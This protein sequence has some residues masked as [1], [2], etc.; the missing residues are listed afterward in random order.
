M[1]D[2]ENLDELI[3]NTKYV[4]STLFNK[5]YLNFN[6]KNK[7]DQIV[8]LKKVSY[9]YISK[10]N[11]IN[12][13]QNIFLSKI[14]LSF[15]NI[16]NRYQPSNED[17][18][19][20]NEC[21]EYL[22]TI[23]KHAGNSE[24]IKIKEF[25]VEE[26]VLYFIKDILKYSLNPVINTTPEMK[27]NKNGLHLENFK[28]TESIKKG[29]L[30]FLENNKDV[31]DYFKEINLKELI[32]SNE[33]EIL[34]KIYEF[35]KFKSIIKRKKYRLKDGGDEE[36]LYDD[37]GRNQI[38]KDNSMNKSDHSK[39]LDK[40]EL[41]NIKKSILKGWRIKI[42]LDNILNSNLF[43]Y[44]YKDIN[45]NGKPQ[46]KR[47]FL[48]DKYDMPDDNDK[49]IKIFKKYLE[50]KTKAHNYIIRYKNYI[51]YKADIYLD[52]DIISKQQRDEVLHEE[53]HRGKS[54]KEINEIK[55]LPDVTC[56][57]SFEY[58]KDDETTKH[59]YRD[60]NVLVYGL[61]GKLQGFIFMIN[62][63][64]NADYINENNESNN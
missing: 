45:L 35:I 57:S 19:L 50:F 8:Y 60:D 24:L 44:S 17:N 59:S 43:E 64:C 3:D 25:T 15:L 38:M 27:W 51:N 16:I 23:Q 36:R 10:K 46:Y 40:N 9:V 2:N 29:L 49:D 30:I 54:N 47:L 12:A 42:S 22:S 32:L 20:K 34:N 62:E 11:I 14:I 21:E 5:I 6:S 18:S 41:R 1:D 4:F 61:Y 7:A 37:Y 39:K 52:L 58:S 55:D 56:T 13:E 63:L 28:I 53:S 31:E 33:I 26:V 48:D